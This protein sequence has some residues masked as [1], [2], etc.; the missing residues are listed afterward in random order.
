MY[1]RIEISVVEVC[2]RVGKAVVSVAKKAQIKH[3]ELAVH[4][5]AVKKS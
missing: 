3:A 5:V 1:E 2:Q 4:F